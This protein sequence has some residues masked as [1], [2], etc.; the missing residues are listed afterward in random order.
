MNEID[1]AYNVVHDYPGGSESLAPRVGK[2]S[3]TLSHEVALVGTAKLGLQTAVKLSVASGDL[4]ILQAFAAQCG[5]MLLPLPGALSLS[6]NDCIKRLG[7][8]LR[9]SGAVVRETV[10]DLEDGQVSFNE[11]RR[12]GN[13]CALLMRSISALVAAVDAMYLE[14]QASRAGGAAESFNA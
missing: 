12:I 13:E 2:N 14:G 11:R 10:A 3:T 8:V 6:G 9:D 5:Q 7:D 4:R 1:A